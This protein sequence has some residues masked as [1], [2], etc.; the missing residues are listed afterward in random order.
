MGQNTKDQFWNSLLTEKSWKILH[1]LKKGYSFIVIGGWA[2][3]L[4]TRQ[5]KSKDIDILVSI[6]ELAKF[7]TEDLRKM[8]G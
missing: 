1:E 4:L 3:Y 8:T 2:V 7:K 5:Q 6:L